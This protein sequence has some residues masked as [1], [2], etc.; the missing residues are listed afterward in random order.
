MIFETERLTVRPWTAD[1]A[2]AAF[3][4]YRDPEVTRYLGNSRT[5]TELADSAAWIARLAERNAALT[6]GLG[7]WAATLREADRPIGLL[8]LAPLDG[9]SE[10]EVGYHLGRDW[11]GRGYA[12]E[13]ARGGLDY[14][15]GGLGLGRIVGVTFP[16]NVASQRVLLKAGL[17]H[18]G[19]GSYYGHELEYFALDAADRARPG[20][21]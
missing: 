13:L 2:A 19:R 12:T 4:I 1:D 6:G 11:W 15:F 7:L 17:R 16:E 3:A 9:G 5:H 20:R 14:G 8:A 10:I 18:E 21:G